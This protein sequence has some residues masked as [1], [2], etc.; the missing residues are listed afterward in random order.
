VAAAG[1]RGQSLNAA[2]HFEHPHRLYPHFRCASRMTPPSQTNCLQTAA[3]EAAFFH[4]GLFLPHCV[5]L[6]AVDLFLQER[7]YVQ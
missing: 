7:P 6:F 3:N 1:F 5:F 2:L 4:A